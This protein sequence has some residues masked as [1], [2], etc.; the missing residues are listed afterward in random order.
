VTGSDNNLATLTYSLGNG[1]NFLTMTT[2]NEPI[3]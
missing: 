1:Q 3:R 2:S